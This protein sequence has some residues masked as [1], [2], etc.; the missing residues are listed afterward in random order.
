[1]ARK[2]HGCCSHRMAEPALFLAPAL[3]SC[4]TLSSPWDSRLGCAPH[5]CPQ[6]RGQGW[7]K[8]GDLGSH[9]QGG[10][11]GLL[12]DVAQYNAGCEAGEPR[13]H[14]TMCLHGVVVP[15]SPAVR[16]DSSWPRMSPLA[17]RLAP[18]PRDWG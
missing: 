16:G 12:F 5:C 11:Q 1:M 8:L 18:G 6:P 14:L 4:G 2:G 3:V 17:G 10:G 9:H 15:L 7:C 13:S